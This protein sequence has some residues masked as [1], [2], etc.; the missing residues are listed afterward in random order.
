MD[1]WN[2][3]LNSATEYCFQPLPATE[4]DR[5]S[6]EIPIEK[7]FDRLLLH[8]GLQTIFPVSEN[9]DVI[10]NI[11]RGALMSLIRFLTSGTCTI[12]GWTDCL[13]LYHTATMYDVRYLKCLCEEFFAENPIT[14]E[15]VHEIH[16]LATRMGINPVIQ[17]SA[18]VLD[19]LSRAHRGSVP[20]Y[21]YCFVI[22]S[23]YIAPL[24]LKVPLGS[25][26]CSWFDGCE[27]D[28]V[29]D[30]ILQSASRKGLFHILGIQ[31]KLKLDNA[32]DMSALKIY[33]E[34]SNDKEYIRFQEQRSKITSLTPVIR[35][36]RNL[37][38]RPEQLASIH[39]TIHNIK[40]KYCSTLK[41][42]CAFQSFKEGKLIATFKSNRT[43][44][45]KNETR[46]FI[47]SV[48]YVRQYPKAVL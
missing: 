42:T 22:N 30:I 41:K 43:G 27:A 45:N 16:P 40:P 2:I 24:Q 31:I 17:A 35:F 37:L 5:Q 39:V 1:R 6:I 38:L 26:K 13:V 8:P 7:M 36:R 23:E 9:R 33:V 18:K 48:L 32:D 10:I 20:P 21:H 44:S 11:T 15:N 4:G 25:I 3:S 28:V 29:N 46:F 47:E 14:A 19:E 12:N 34:A